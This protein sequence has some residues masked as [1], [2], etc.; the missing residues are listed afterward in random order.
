MFFYQIIVLCVHSNS[1]LA[2]LER[3]FKNN[4]SCQMKIKKESHV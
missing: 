4:Y 1:N 3:E 2:V